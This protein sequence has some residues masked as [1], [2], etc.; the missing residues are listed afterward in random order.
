MNEMYESNSLDEK[1]MMEWE[2]DDNQTWV[3]LQSYWGYMW[4]KNNNGMEEQLP[5]GYALAKAQ[6]MPQKPPTTP[7]KR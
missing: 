2:D 3:H 7:T 4:E 1:E 6:S 5:V